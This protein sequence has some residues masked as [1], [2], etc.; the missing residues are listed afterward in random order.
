MYFL[1]A[2]LSS[3]FPQDTLN[4]SK[5]CLVKVFSFTHW[6]ILFLMLSAISAPPLH[7]ISNF[8]EQTLI[9]AG[10]NKHSKTFHTELEAEMSC[11][12]EQS[13]SDDFD[14]E[15]DLSKNSNADNE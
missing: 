11:A 7:Q 15:S 13:H 14:F 3:W 6:T 1:C 4:R 10:P 9:T 12:L 2:H 8:I 5:D